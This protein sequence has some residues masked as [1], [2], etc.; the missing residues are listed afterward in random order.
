MCAGSVVSSGE[1]GGLVT[2]PLGR[3]VYGVTVKETWETIYVK[4]VTIPI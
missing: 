2:T 3:A 4:T 1:N